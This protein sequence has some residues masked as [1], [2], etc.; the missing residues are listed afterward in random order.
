MEPNG[1]T[2]SVALGN[3]VPLH[4]VILEQSGIWNLSGNPYN[5]LIGSFPY[6]APERFDRASQDGPPADVFS[7]G[8]TL[9]EA[10]AGRALLD[11]GTKELFHLAMDEP[12]HRLRIRG[13][14]EGIGAEPLRALLATLLDYD[15]DARPTMAELGPRLASG[16]KLGDE[17]RERLL[18]LARS[19]ST[20]F[21][22]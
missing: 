2:G 12:S 19:A 17:E 6:L 10:V 20:P 18:A 1:D 5:A 13:A 9:Y 21:R 22:A 11:L 14:L 4:T 8:C 7:L 16:E 3:D 15:P